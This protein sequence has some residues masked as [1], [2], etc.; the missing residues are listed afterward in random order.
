MTYVVYISNVIVATSSLSS[1]FSV[2]VN[3]LLPKSGNG[4]MQQYFFSESNK[5]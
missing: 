3:A 5:L 2:A 4:F 1:P